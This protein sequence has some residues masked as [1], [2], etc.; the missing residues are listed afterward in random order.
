M[1]QFMADI[2]YAM[3]LAIHGESALKR[4]TLPSVR[5]IR[6][7]SEL[8]QL[9]GSI[10]KAKY[11]AADIETGGYD[12]FDHLRD[13]ILSVAYCWEPNRVFI[14]PEHLVPLTRYIYTEAPNTRF[15]WHNGKFDQKFHVAQGIRARVD[16]DTMLLSYAIDETKGIH[17]LEQLTSDI[18]GAPDW[19]FMIKPYL[20]GK[21]K[22]YADIPPAVLYDYQARDTSSTLQIFP[23]LR[24]LVN[25]DSKLETLYTRTL[26]PMSDYLRRIEMVGI[27]PDLPQ[28]EKNR[29]K[30]TKEADDLERRFNEQAIAAGYGVLNPRSPQ[31]VSHFLYDVLKLRDP[32]RPNRRPVSTD[33]ETLL[34]LQKHPAV[35]IL[36]QYRGVHKGL[37]T[38]VNSVQEHIGADGR[39]HTTYLIHGTTTGRLASRDPNLLNIPRDPELRGQFKA[40]QVILELP[41]KGGTVCIRYM[42]MEIDVNQAELR[43]LGELAKDPILFQIYTDPHSPSIHEVTRGEMYGDPNSYT[44]ADWEHHYAKFSVDSHPRVLEEQKMQAKNV[45]FGIVYGR[46]APTFAEEFGVSP[47]EAQQWLDAWFNKYSGARTFLNRCRQAPLKGENLC[48]PFGRKRRFQVVNQEKLKDIQNQ[49]SNFP[50]QSIASDCVTH[51]GMRVQERAAL[52]FDANIVNTVYDSILF[53]LPNSIPQAL[54]LGAYVLKT[55]RAVPR[56]WGLTTIPFSGDIKLGSDWGH[57]EKVPLPRHLKKDIDNA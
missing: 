20:K 48:T 43:V 57:L 45:N 52:E 33:E 51:T 44:S 38:Y 12:G 24:N 56:E 4:Y 54:K 35:E 25:L 16:E 6:T 15:I 1:R 34:T 11:C 27:E 23:F 13:R 53:E 14:V 7:A 46:T 31:Q 18:L 28:V 50:M 10:S 49:A 8:R 5:V 39:V 19:K 21:D 40:K 55:L 17:D 37:S 29:V 26:L 47:K 42:F 2:D 22:T 41:N 30:K 36:L 9:V 3:R 32:R